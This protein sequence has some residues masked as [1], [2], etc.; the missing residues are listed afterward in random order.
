MLKEKQ[1]CLAGIIVGYC[2]AVV[3]TIELY[4]SYMVDLDQRP[5]KKNVSNSALMLSKIWRSSRHIYRRWCVVH[6]SYS[7][8]DNVTRTVAQSSSA[9]GFNCHSSPHIT[10]VNQRSTFP[11]S[12]SSPHFLEPIPGRFWAE[13]YLMDYGIL[14]LVGNYLL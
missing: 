13:H 3:A 1:F 6:Y 12:A 7:T 4:M 2:V 10:V 8:Y 11:C 5:E 14:R 9:G